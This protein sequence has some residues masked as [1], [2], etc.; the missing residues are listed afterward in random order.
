MTG[1]GHWES[2]DFTDVSLGLFSDNR[3]QEER[4]NS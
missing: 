3:T 4:D 1:I 2:I